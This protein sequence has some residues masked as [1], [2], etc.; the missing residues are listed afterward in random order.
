MKCNSCR[1]ATGSKQH[2]CQVSG[3]TFDVL[4]QASI[5]WD[6]EHFKHL[7]EQLLDRWEGH[8]VAESLTRPAQCT[9]NAAS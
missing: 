4:V 9:E 3:A 6:D 2:S 7:M 5:A 1:L 8:W